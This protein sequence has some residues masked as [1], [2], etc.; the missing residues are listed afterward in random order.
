[1]RTFEP[2]TK[3]YIDDV[4]RNQLEQITS[5]IQSESEGYLL[6]VKEDEY[7]DHLISEFT[8]ETPTIDFESMTI[9]PTEKMIPA[10]RHPSA[11]FFMDD[12]DRSF[13]RQV[14]IYHFPFSG[15]I[16][17]LDYVPNPHLV[18]TEEF[19]HDDSSEV[20]EIT[21][22][23]INFSDDPETI[24]RESERTIGNLKTQLGHIK[25]QV[26]GHNA[27]LRQEITQRVQER[28]KDLM[29][30]SDFLSKLGVPVKKKDNLPET[31]SIPTP[32]IPKKIIPRPPV[33]TTDPNP[34]PALDLVTYNEILQ[35]IHDVGKAIER[36]PSTYR[37]K[38]EEALRDH[39][40]M[41]LE[42]RFQGSATGETFNKTGKTD[43]L[44]RYENS[45]VFVAECKYWGGEKLY[46]E[47][48]DQILKYLT[49]RDS[50]AAVIVFVKNA[51]F[52]SVIQKVKEVTPTHANFV[53]FDGQKEE[54]FLSYKVSLNGDP[55][56]KLFLTVLLFHFPET[57]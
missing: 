15:D 47:T 36:M 45:N 9:S 51:D 44:L 22:E 12:M 20:E 3:G 55:D 11:M 7:I 25:N 38:T 41:S 6:N 50:K 56:R 35:V 54:T 53:S 1:M 4:L 26:D 2:F 33:T 39:F 32:K 57:N 46:L 37:G 28:K 42:P 31:F 17:I 5:R 13:K 8:L 16:N 34:D 21:F 14:I 29:K 24:K 18:W 40:L 48:I 19:T 10:R 27:N 23:I 43:I 30:K 52:S 49:W